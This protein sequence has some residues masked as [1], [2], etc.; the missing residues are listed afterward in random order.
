MESEYKDLIVEAHYHWK[1]PV[2]HDDNRYWFCCRYCEMHFKDKNRMSFYRYNDE[3]EGWSGPYTLKMYPTFDNNDHAILKATLDERGLKFPSNRAG[4]GIRD[5][6][7]GEKTMDADVVQKVR[8]SQ[9]IETNKEHVQKHFSRVGEVEAGGSKGREKKKVVIE[10]K[11]PRGEEGDH[12]NIGE[13]K[14]KR[15]VI[16]MADDAADDRDS[17]RKKN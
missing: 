1:D 9:V 11:R 12:P 13:T 6:H 16:I 15:K 4:R 14:K 17:G 5:F 7:K 3:C 2:K 10:V 8:G